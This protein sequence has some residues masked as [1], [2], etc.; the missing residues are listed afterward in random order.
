MQTKTQKARCR[1]IPTPSEDD[2]QEVVG[3]LEKYS[4]ADYEDAP[5]YVTVLAHLARNLKVLADSRKEIADSG[6]EIH[7]DEEL[8]AI[9]LADSIEIG[10]E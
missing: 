6:I 7:S 10:G 5:I 2:I 9:R 8:E 3:W 1:V 4:D